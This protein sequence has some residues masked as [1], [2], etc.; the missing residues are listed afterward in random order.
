MPRGITCI[1][2]V[3]FQGSGRSLS[4][5][6]DTVKRGQVRGSGATEMGFSSIG[7]WMCGP[8][9][10]QAQRGRG[11]AVRG[12]PRLAPQL[13]AAAT[14]TCDRPAAGARGEGEASRSGGVP[15]SPWAV[16]EGR[17]PGPPMARPSGILHPF[18]IRHRNAA[19]ALVNAPPVS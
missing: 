13:R 3:T 5:Q 2:C 17:I 15:Q 6:P 18:G 4:F 7:T 19:H 10:L 11:N 8:C 14:C 9:R 1:T 12:A 16:I